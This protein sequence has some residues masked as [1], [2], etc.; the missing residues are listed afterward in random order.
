M[1]RCI[2]IL[3]LIYPLRLFAQPSND[4]P[5]NAIPLTV[6]TTTCSYTVGT[7]AGATPVNTT[8]STV[9][10]P[11]C[12]FYYGGDVWYS[13]VV[14]ANGVLIVDTDEGTMTDSGM[15]FYSGSC[16]SLTLIECDDSDSPNGTMSMINS[17]GLV[18]GST[19]YIRIWA[20]GNSGNGTFGICAS[21]PDIPANNEP[22]NATD[23]PVGSSCS[24]AS[25]TNLNA[26][27]S[28]GIPAPGCGAYLGGDVWFTVTV[29]STGAVV[30]DTQTGTMTDGGMA[31]YTASACNGTFS[32]VS[33][34]DD[35]SPNGSMPKLT[36][37]GQT[38]GSTLYIRIWEFNNDNPG[39]FG[40]CATV[41]GP[42]GFPETSD[43]CPDPSPI[44]QGPGLFSSTTDGTFSPDL[45]GNLASIFCGTI[46]NN[47]WYQFTASA[48]SE[49]FPITSVTG[50]ALGFGIQGV[51]YE[52]TYN[53]NG[54]CTGFTQVSNC[55]SPS[56]ATTGTI[57]ATGL[58]PGLEY[59]LMIDGYSNDGCEF[60]ISGW[61]EIATMG[62]EL[63][64]FTGAD[65][66]E[67]IA[68]FWTTVSESNSS[69]FE[70]LHSRNGTDYEP[71]ASLPGA[72]TTPETRNYS[73]LHENPP[74]GIN[75]Y[76]LQQRDFDGTTTAFDPISVVHQTTR[77]G[78]VSVY[79]NP[80]TDKLMLEFDSAHEHT[81][82]LRVY[83]QLGVIVAGMDISVS[84]GHEVVQLKTD[85]Y[86][87][88]IYVLET[89]SGDLKEYHRIAKTN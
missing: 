88:G 75:Y 72:G 52:V 50:C 36:V 42:C 19:V 37:L 45:P 83:N 63:T 35:S 69:N 41:T 44:V 62:A 78:L 46:E 81:V 1:N 61:N 18:P 80:A 26:T 73:Y 48:T 34:D 87:E 22:C 32:L 27:A 6:N 65:L 25:A 20:W 74:G 71:L 67:G 8:T 77:E 70:L 68:V 54:C 12:A 28:S 31:V 2:P 56:T 51:V 10:A 14:P 89:I 49:S 86:P 39:T 66:T 58:S 17:T 76:R 3:L 64:T 23:L 11:G 30:I 15:A 55:F 13:A 82:G 16:S 38:P 85:D 24:Y 57:T 79:P 9:A 43:F 59:L 4:D 5:C 47:S 84:K 33:C 40:I 7:N 60:T 21:T 53:A 29:P